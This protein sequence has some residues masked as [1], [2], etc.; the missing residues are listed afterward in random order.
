MDSVLEEAVVS[1]DQVN[2]LVTAGWYSGRD[3][4]LRELQAFDPGTHDVVSC[5]CWACKAF[6]IMIT[7]LHPPIFGRS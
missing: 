3:A 6:Q 5:R 7:K 1:D 2:Q 4:G